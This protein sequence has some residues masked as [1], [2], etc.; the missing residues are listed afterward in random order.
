MAAIEFAKRRRGRRRRDPVCT[1][2][3]GDVLLGGLALLARSVCTA[4]CVVALA[5][6]LS[7]SFFFFFDLRGS[8]ALSLGVRI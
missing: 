2:W 7:S 5:R 3:I 1:A 4:A 8:R 6:A